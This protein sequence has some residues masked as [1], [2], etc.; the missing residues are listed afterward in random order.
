VAAHALK[1]VRAS[2]GM[3]AGNKLYYDLRVDSPDGT[4]TAASS[5]GDYQVAS[6][7]ANYWGSSDRR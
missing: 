2:R 6:W 7:L 5:I 4:H 3:Q 1:R